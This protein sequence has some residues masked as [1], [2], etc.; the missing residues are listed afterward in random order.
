ML[1]TE[2]ISRKPNLYPWADEF[3]KSFWKSF[4][5]PEEFN[6][7]SDYNDF[8]VILKDSEKRVIE[9]SLSA[10]S[11]IEVEVKTFWGDLGKKFKHPSISSLG[12]C[13][14]NTEVIHNDAYEKLLDVLKLEHIFEENLNH[15][16]M[17]GRVKYLKKHLDNVSKDCN[18]QYVYSLILFS[19]L[20]ENI[21]L[22]S[23]FYII[24]Y[25]NRFKNL[26]KDT[27][28]Q[29]A[30][31]ATEESLHAKIGFKLIQTLREEYPELFD[32]ELV[33]LIE[34]RLKK[35]LQYEYEMID[36]MLEGY[37]GDEY[38]NSEVLKAYITNRMNE[39][40]V[41]AGFGQIQF[42]L[43]EDLLEN[44]KWMN[45]ELSLSRMTD[46]F[47]KKP[48]EYSKSSQSFSEDELF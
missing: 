1:F 38:M 32:E 17:K 36:W 41:D 33:K 40:F 20:I 12:Y 26:L 30:Y 8:N 43:N 9:R 6:F 45:E 13:L 34:P 7:Q 29:V 35:A 27:A 44:S 11:Q 42:D 22:F 46:F 15:P 5:T 3:K 48:T 19:I 25:F 18:K 10:I 37:D 24:T 21:S 14:A 39:S 23:Q 16:V 47:Y 2:Q 28:Q 31:T 4:W